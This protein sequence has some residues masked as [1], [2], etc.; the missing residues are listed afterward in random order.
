MGNFSLHGAD[1]NQYFVIKQDDMAKHATEQDNID[2]A[3]I[4]KNIRVS[5]CK[6]N[7]K[8]DNKYFVVNI[9]VD[10]AKDVVEILRQNNHWK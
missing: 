6:F 3:R 4:L 10:Y 8:T 5:R 7:K 2:L 1:F 9:D